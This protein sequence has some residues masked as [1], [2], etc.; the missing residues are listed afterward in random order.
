[1]RVYF[2]LVRR[3]EVIEDDD[4]V[5]VADLRSAQA[6][7]VE[8]LMELKRSARLGRPEWSG[9]TLEMVDISGH[10]LASISLD[11]VHYGQD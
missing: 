2:N 11:S 3:Q 7:V 4:G 9:W 8:A 5:D 1:M 6:E 10:V